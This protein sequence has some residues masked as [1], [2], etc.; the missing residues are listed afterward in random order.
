MRTEIGPGRKIIHSYGPKLFQRDHIEPHW[1]ELRSLTSSAHKEIIEQCLICRVKLVK[2]DALHHPE[3]SST[4]RGRQT[5]RL[6][7]HFTVRWFRH[8]T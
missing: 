2:S 5:P 7:V 4:A 8:D 1:P 3:C 6:V